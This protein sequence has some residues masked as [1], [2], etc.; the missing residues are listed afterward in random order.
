VK[1]ETHRFRCPR[2]GRWR[3]VVAGSERASVGE[4]LSIV[5]VIVK[6]LELR[7]GW[8]GKRMVSSSFM[9]KN[10]DF[11]LVVVEVIL[12]EVVLVEVVL[13]EGEIVE[14]LAPPHPPLLPP[15]PSV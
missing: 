6:I 5:V 7:G 1:E 13:D 11:P 10:G 15:V 3:W 9:W 2:L 14:G 8:V 4:M 12:V